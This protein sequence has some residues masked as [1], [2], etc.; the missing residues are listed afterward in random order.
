VLGLTSYQEA[1][2]ALGRAAATSRSVS[3]V[4]HAEAGYVEFRAAETHAC[5]QI[6]SHELEQIIV[7]SLSHR[8]EHRA[9]G[10]SADVL[11]AVGRALDQL[12]ALDV[13]VH[14]SRDRLSVQ[15]A[16]PR[17]AARELSYVGEELEELRRAA[18]ARRNGQP[19]RRILI[20]QA[21]PQAAS[22]IL[23]LL[24]AE[25]A[26]QALPTRYAP[27]IAS[28]PEPPDLVLA[29]SSPTVLE[30]VRALRSGRHT[31]GLPIVALVGSECPLPPDDLFA[32]GVD[33]LLQE[34]VLP[35]QL[36]ARLRTWLLRGRASP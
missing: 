33:D 2:R 31:G 36:R 8:G 24:A 10:D 3:I 15:F 18:A 19:L 12:G 9:A 1:L 7:N 11:R 28:G 27:A 29:Q 14:L 17:G 21:G 34:P 22:G 20:L 13:S 4:E 5:R 25:F 30:A 6:S 32:A 23:E 26:V 16:D 35:A